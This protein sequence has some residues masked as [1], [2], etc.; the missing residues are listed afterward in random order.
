MNYTLVVIDM[1]KRF[2]KMIEDSKEIERKCLRLINNAA[3]V[4]SPILFVEYK[5]CGKTIST[6]LKEAKSLT[7]KVYR[8]IKSYDDG[9]EEILYALNKYK[10]PEHIKVCG[11]NTDACVAASVEGYLSASF[12]NIKK[13]RPSVHVITKACGSSICHNNGVI[14][15]Q[16]LSYDFPNLKVK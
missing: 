8:V 13:Q 6:L 11:V 14:D 12:Y 1:Q 4:K 5:E 15:L 16:R 10:L 2:L 7:D 9:G 3:K